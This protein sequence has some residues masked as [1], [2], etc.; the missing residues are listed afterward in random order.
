MRRDGAF[1]QRA[2]FPQTG[3]G[4]ISPA[5]DEITVSGFPF[6]TRSKGRNRSGGNDSTGAQRGAAKKAARLFRRTGAENVGTGGKSCGAFNA[7]RRAFVQRGFS[8]NRSRKHISHDRRNNR[9]RVSLLPSKRWAE[10]Q[11]GG[12][13][14]T[15]AQRGAAK[16]AA[17][18]FP[19]TGA[20][21]VGFGGRSCGAFDAPRRTFVQRGCSR[22]PEPGTY[23]P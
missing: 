4:N 15:G 12:N 23:L 13:D 5:T 6:P 8:A 17:R 9:Q 1:V 14:S 22:K 10:S 3:A 21:N 11:S 20:G 7:P 2:D 19:W 16:K 18:L